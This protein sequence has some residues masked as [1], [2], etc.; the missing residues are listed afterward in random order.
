MLRLE[1][2]DAEYGDSAASSFV[3][4]SGRNLILRERLHDGTLV[5]FGTRVVSF[6]VLCDCVHIPNGRQCSN[7]FGERFQSD[8]LPLNRLD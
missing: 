6:L 7:F 4:S 8:P 5:V 3:G 2:R 1:A